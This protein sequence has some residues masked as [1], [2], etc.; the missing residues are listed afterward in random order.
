MKKPK[1]WQPARL[2]RATDPR[3]EAAYARGRIVRRKMLAAEGGSISAEEAAERLGI[4]RTTLLRRYHN[5]RVLGWKEPGEAAV[6]FPVWQFKGDEILHGL[7]EVLSA[8]ANGCPELDDMGRIGFFFGRF[9]FLGRRRPLDLLRNGQI[10][11]AL[12]A[13]QA[14]TQ[15]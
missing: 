13:T 10:A 14:F 3:V 6:H 4:T 9:G 7:P 1:A 2:S 5:G 8:L 15:P 12:L 11:D